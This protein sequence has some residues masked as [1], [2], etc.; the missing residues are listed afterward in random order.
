MRFIGLVLGLTLVTSHVGAEPRSQGVYDVALRGIRGATFSFASVEE[1]GR[2]STTGKVTTSGIVA[3]IRRISYFAKTQGS[4]RA[5]RYVPSRY[6]ESRTYAGE[7]SGSRIAY[8]GGVPVSRVYDPPRPN[9]KA[10]IDFATQGDAIDVM[11]AAFALFRDMPRDEVCTF[12]SF[13]FDGTRRAQVIMTGPRVEGAFLVCD[14]EYRRI[15]GYS[16]REMTE[17][18]SRF[19]FKMSYGEAGNGL[20]HPKRV[21]MNTTYGR[22]RMVRR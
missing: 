22:G 10:K 1:G 4:I 7:V 21:D 5:G 6:E 14:A 19:S 13:L 18:G 17:E 9:Y 8:R 16:E 3:A 15:D 2:Y 12:N 20:W 11:T